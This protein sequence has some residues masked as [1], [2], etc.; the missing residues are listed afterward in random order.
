MS[1]QRLWWLHLA[2]SSGEVPHLYTERRRTQ[3]SHL[4]SHVRRSTRSPAPAA[5]AWHSGSVSR[6]P[7]VTQYF[8]AL[9]TSVFMIA[10][11]FCIVWKI[12]C[13]LHA[14]KRQ[15]WIRISKANNIRYNQKQV[16]T[17]QFDLMYDITSCGLTSR[18]SI[19]E[20]MT[21]FS[22]VHNIGLI[23]F[24]HNFHIRLAWFDTSFSQFSFNFLS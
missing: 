4:L 23:W 15:A 22:V 19:I 1:E 13:D 6:T 20:R 17:F 24:S 8:H 18:F 9:W 12:L 11:C 14:E 21:L 10:T 16:E 3:L 5:E 7:R 2:L